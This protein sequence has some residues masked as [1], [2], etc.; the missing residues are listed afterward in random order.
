MGWGCGGG[1]YC[2]AFIGLLVSITWEFLYCWI[3][4]M[5]CLTM[6]DME[7]VLALGVVDFMC[8]DRIVCW[9]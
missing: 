7:W 5:K 1:Y 6:E 9:S 8:G 3:V 2:V 4:W